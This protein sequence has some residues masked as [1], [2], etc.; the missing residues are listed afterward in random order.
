[1]VRF[2]PIF[3]LIFVYCWEAMADES[4]WQLIGQGGG[5][6]SYVDTLSLEGVGSKVDTL[7]DGTTRAWALVNLEKPQLFE[8]MS[9]RSMKNYLVS[10]CNRNTIATVDTILYSDKQGTGNIV[11]QEKG[12]SL[13]FSP[14]RPNTVEFVIHNYLCAPID[15]T[16]TSPQYLSNYSIPS[17]TRCT[18]GGLPY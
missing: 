7:F 12:D 2:V 13:Q 18:K 11:A 6:T 3:M 8:G 10:N 5:S 15:C 16:T 14:V 1:M 4:N 17:M 9:V